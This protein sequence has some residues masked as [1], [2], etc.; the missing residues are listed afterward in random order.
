[1]AV[2]VL[3]ILLVFWAILLKRRKSVK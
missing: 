1:L 3:P 2:F